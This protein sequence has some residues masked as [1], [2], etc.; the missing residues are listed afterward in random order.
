MRERLTEL[1]AAIAAP[2]PS[3]NLSPQHAQ[4][5]LVVHVD[6]KKFVHSK[7]VPHS[8]AC[9]SLFLVASKSADRPTTQHRRERLA[10]SRAGRR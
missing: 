6:A 1:S 9:E 8:P 7:E 3:G 5:E 10:L 4:G 2:R